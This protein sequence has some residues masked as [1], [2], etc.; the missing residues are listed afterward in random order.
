MIG[1]LALY[2]DQIAPETDEID[3]RVL[4]WLPSSARIGYLPSSPDPD[5]TWFQPRADYYGRYGHRLE[6]FGLEDEF[7]ALRTNDLRSCK[8]IHLSGGNTYGFSTGSGSE[9]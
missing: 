7:D 4:S 6:F 1:R 9:A 3:R 5:R 2:S 8:A